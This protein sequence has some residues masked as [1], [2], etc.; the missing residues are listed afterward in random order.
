MNK[1]ASLAL[2]IT[3]IVVIV[4]AFVVLGLGLSLT[5]TIFKGAESK[6]PEA[7]AV[8]QL[9]AE[10]TSENT[11]TIPQTVEI[12]HKDSKTMQ[13]GFYN[14][15]VNTAVGATFEMGDCL[16]TGGGLIDPSNQ[17]TIASISQ[18]VGPSE[19]YGY[20]IILTEN[21]LTGGQTYICT[22]KA[23]CSPDSGASCGTEPYDKKQFFL[24]VVS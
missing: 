13:I 1:K 10:P 23:V 6:L 12:D 9:E 14:K 18:D 7:F 3:A 16:K 11:I 21:G 4:I 20:S 2:S 24:Q 5:R 22:I 8:T 15:G 17:P 19:A